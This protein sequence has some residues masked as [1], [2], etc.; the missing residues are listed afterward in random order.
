MYR[1]SSW[2]EKK[3][4][5]KLKKI[6]KIDAL[7]LGYSLTCI[8]SC[9]TLVKKR[10]FIEVGGFNRELY[11]SS[12]AYPGYLMLDKHNVYKTNEPLG[13]YR[14]SVNASLKKETILGFIEANQYFR[15]YVYT[16]NIFSKLYGFLLGDAYFSKNVDEWISRAMQYDVEIT[17][18]DIAGIKEYKPCK[19]R[20]KL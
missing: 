12:D 4:W 11:P 18:D 9:G 16:E 6:R 15:E 13:Y 14:W 1:I 2:A 20:K 8:P 17:A 3:I 10:D 5:H 19:I 7:I